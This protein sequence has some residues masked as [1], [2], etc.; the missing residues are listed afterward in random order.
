MVTAR[1]FGGTLASS[2]LPMAVGLALGT[3]G[4]VATILVVGYL[5]RRRTAAASSMAQE[6]SLWRGRR[7]GRSGLA[8]VD[9]VIEAGK[10]AERRGRQRDLAP[11][12]GRGRRR[13]VR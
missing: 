6:N 12:G 3:N 9:V 10:S 13:L 2:L 5:A 8:L 11:V 1:I 4:P 7:L